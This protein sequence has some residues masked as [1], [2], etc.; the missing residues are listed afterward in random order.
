MA[1]RCSKKELEEKIIKFLCGECDDEAELREVHRRLFADDECLEYLLATGRVMREIRECEE[2]AGEPVDWDELKEKFNRLAKL[3]EEPAAAV[4]S[5]QGARRPP[6][7]GTGKSGG[8][9]GA[10]RRGR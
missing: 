7:R 5:G 1:R 3:L 6:A 10:G 4:E 9:S 8:K 2:D